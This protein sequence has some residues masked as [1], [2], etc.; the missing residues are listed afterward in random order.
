[1]NLHSVEDFMELTYR[2][3]DMISLILGL[4]NNHGSCVIQRAD[5]TGRDGRQVFFFLCFLRNREVSGIFY[6]GASL[7]VWP[8]LCG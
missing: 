2:H 7:W 6:F 8:H 4:H 1:M 5:R 3:I